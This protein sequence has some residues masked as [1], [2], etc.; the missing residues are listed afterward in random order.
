MDYTRGSDF[1]SSR[2]GAGDFALD[3]RGVPG[4]DR[5]VLPA[6]ENLA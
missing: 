5:G 1:D 3:R 6:A 2:S 4:G